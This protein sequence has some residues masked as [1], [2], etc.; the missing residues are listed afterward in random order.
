MKDANIAN[1]GL[2]PGL[3]SSAPPALDAAALL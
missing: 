1:P 2:T 3:H